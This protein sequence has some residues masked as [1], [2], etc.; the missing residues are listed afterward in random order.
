MSTKRSLNIFWVVPAILVV[1]TQQAQAVR[2]EDFG[3]QLG[4]GEA[5]LVTVVLNLIRAALGVIGILAVIMILLGGFRWL[6]S[7]G[8]EEKILQAKRTIGAT[9]VGL[10][11]ILLS[12]AIVNF[13]INTTQNVSGIP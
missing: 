8:D 4:L 2:F 11:I 13:V 1:L 3:P 9:I 10:I 5:D 7:G 12:W 6:L